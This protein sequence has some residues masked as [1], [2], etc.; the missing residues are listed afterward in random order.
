MPSEVKPLLKILLRFL[1]T[2]NMRT[3]NVTPKIYLLEMHGRIALPPTKSP[4]QAHGRPSPLTKAP[5]AARLVA[6]AQAVDRKRSNVA[7]SDGRSRRNGHTTEYATVPPRSGLVNMK[8][9][10][11]R[12]WR[13][14]KRGQESREGYK[15]WRAEKPGWDVQQEGVVDGLGRGR[16]SHHD[17]RLLLPQFFISSGARGPVNVTDGIAKDI[18]RSRRGYARHRELLHPDGI[19]SAFC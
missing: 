19:A 5:L 18:A 4:T 13:P 11:C 1:R 7:S 12:T 14:G 10:I 16:I 17:V 9:D 8:R 3:A 6:P 15:K 2:L